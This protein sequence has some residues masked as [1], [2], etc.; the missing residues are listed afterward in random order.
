VQRD[1]DRQGRP[2]QDDEDERRSDGLRDLGERRLVGR[3]PGVG[4]ET[5]TQGRAG[6]GAARHAVRQPDRRKVDAT[7]HEQGWPAVVREHAPRGERE[8]DQGR[9]L[10]AERA[11][12]PGTVH[13]QQQ[14][15]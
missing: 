1:G 2:E 15:Q 4:E 12:Q 3:H 5:Q 7:D 6:C 8:R 10:Q 13:V 11:E 14:V 9:E